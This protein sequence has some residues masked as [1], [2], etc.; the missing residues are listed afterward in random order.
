MLPLALLLQLGASIPAIYQG[1][2]G[3]TGNNAEDDP[4][5]KAILARAGVLK[6]QTSE[7][8][9]EQMTRG[10]AGLG[11]DE[12]LGSSK[13]RDFLLRQDK[14]KAMADAEVDTQVALARAGAQDTAKQRRTASLTNLFKTVGGGAMAAAGYLSGGPV[15]TA[16]ELKNGLQ[17]MTQA[18][19]MQQVLG[20]TSLGSASGGLLASLFTGEME[21][22]SANEMVAG[23]QAL[24]TP[25]ISELANHYMNTL[26]IGGE[27]MDVS[28]IELLIKSGM[29]DTL[30]TEE[31]LRL[32]ILKRR[33]GSRV[34]I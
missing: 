28:D 29:G 8:Y 6:A 33:R 24:T 2:R 34:S 30:S 4:T 32:E 22:G 7:R 23:I 31:M 19:K 11:A 16:D 20:Y 15:R 9:S 14:N 5:L 12:M 21:A 26:N 27:P 1:I 13:Q 10:I 18:D 3:L 25:D 17:G